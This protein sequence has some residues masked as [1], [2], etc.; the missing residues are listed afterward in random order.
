MKPIHVRF[1]WSDG[2]EPFA[3]IDMPCAPD[4][5]EL[6]TVPPI[7]PGEPKREGHVVRREWHVGW[8]VEV[9]VTIVRR[10]K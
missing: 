5:G 8:V 6:V 10:E 1:S 9:H 2:K 7:R 3:A 4:V